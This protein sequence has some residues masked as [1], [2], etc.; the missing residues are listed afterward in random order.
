M[1]NKIFLSLVLTVLLA[2]CTTNTSNQK[3]LTV[4]IDPQ[5]FFLEAIVGDKY[6]VNSLIP[7]G[8]NPES[9]DPT[10]SQ[11]ISLG[12][13]SIY[14]K[15]GYLSFEN[16]WVK[17]VQ[18]N[19]PQMQIVDCSVG[20]EALECS[21]HGHDDH[22]HHS[23]GGHEGEDPHIWSSPST[24]KIMVNNMY[25]AIIAADTDN[26]DYYAGNYTQ[27]I[28]K[29]DSVD[30]VI[31][32]YLE[33]SDKRSFIIYH[34]ALSYLALEYGLNQYSIEQEGKSPSPAQLKQLI[35]LAKEQDVKVV[36][37]QAEYDKK[38][39]EVIAREIGAKLVSINLL[40]YNWADEMI[41]IAKSLVSE[42]E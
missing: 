35:D 7:A 22:H 19:T 21:G 16:V 4:S 8:A 38:N 10:P 5:K 3:M 36:F 27:L 24:A 40:S 9:Y 14:F 11:M 15:V 18:E 13:S 1:I 6:T 33:K 42:S 31:R 17:N 2:G 20:I 26:K 12:K 39:A 37:I 23:H 41:N 29:I 25:N 28:N 34:P 32:H 30:T